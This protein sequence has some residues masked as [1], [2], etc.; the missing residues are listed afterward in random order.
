MSYWNKT[1]ELSVL[2]GQTIESIQQSDDEIIF[3]TK[4]GNSYKMYHEQN[5]CE[6]V[7]IDDINGNLQDLVGQEILLAEEVNNTYDRFKGKSNYNE[8]GEYVGSDGYIPES[9]TWTF[10]NIG[11]LKDHIQIRWLGSSNGYY[12]E[13]VSFI[14]LSEKEEED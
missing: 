9:Y 2:K 13:G 6:G 14:D 5:C 11:T 8:E 7:Y 4:E 3:N 10:Y 12:S 1:I